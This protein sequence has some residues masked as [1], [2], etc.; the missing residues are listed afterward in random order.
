MLR[1]DL[2]GHFANVLREAGSGGC[3]S[4][5]RR[6][7]PRAR[8]QVVARIHLLNPHLQRFSAFTAKNVGR[9][10]VAD[11]GARLA[12]V[13]ALVTL[14]PLRGLSALT[15]TSVERTDGSYVMAGVSSVS[16]RIWHAQTNNVARRPA[17][18]PSHGS[19]VSWLQ[20]LDVARS[21]ARR[22]HSRRAHSEPSRARWAC[23]A[24]DL[25]RLARPRS[26]H[27]TLE[28]GQQL[29]SQ[30]HV[31]T[32]KTRKETANGHDVP[33][34]RRLVGQVLPE[35]SADQR[36][37]RQHEGGRRDPAAEDSRRRHRSRLASE[38][39]AESDSIR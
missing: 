21:R 1:T 33:T 3:F 13:K 2:R 19:G 30:S 36:I 32:F 27:R 34:R 5:L 18:G 29:R 22:P 11:S 10:H 24:T 15:T 4:I 12:V 38:P 14:D 25:D 8:S 16:V 7:V 20:L 9:H 17:H 26:S 35:R 39:Q 6:N 31:T 28:G 37:E 23:N